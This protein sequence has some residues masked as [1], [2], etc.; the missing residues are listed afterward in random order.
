[1][2][3]HNYLQIICVNFDVKMVQVVLKKINSIGKFQSSVA[4]QV[5]GPLE[6]FY[7]HH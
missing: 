4:A 5:M 3:F 7:L 2:F 6:A 1:M